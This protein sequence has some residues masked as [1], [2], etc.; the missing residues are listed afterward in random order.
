MS[1][2]YVTIPQQ[3]SEQLAATNRMQEKMLKMK[4]KSGSM[5]RAGIHLN[6]V[7]IVDPAAN[8]QNGSLLVLKFEGGM[9]IRQLLVG[10]HFLQLLPLHGLTQ[11]IEWPLHTRLPLVGVVRQVIRTM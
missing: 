8:P 2:T 9:V 10:Q 1:S 6:D 3:A 11:A 4:V 5:E 7:L